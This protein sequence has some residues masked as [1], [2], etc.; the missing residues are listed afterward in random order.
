MPAS[1]TRLEALTAGG[2]MMQS[3]RYTVRAGRGAVGAGAGMLSRARFTL[4]NGND[5][6]SEIM[7]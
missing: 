3:G 5:V 1:G 7:R 2:F 6:R 4:M